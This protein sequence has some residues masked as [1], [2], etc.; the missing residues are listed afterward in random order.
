MISGEDISWAMER[1]MFAFGNQILRGIRAIQEQ[2]QA[3]EQ[4]SRPIRRQKS[5]HR[6]HIV[7]HQRLFED[8]FANEP[9]CN[10][11]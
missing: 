11:F 8:Y 2:E 7:A 9:R 6:E 5:V 3:K 1:A 4:V 10:F